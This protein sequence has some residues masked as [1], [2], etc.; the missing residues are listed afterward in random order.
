MG[1]NGL[2][3]DASGAID[4]SSYFSGYDPAKYV[5]IRERQFE[6]AKNI[7]KEKYGGEAE[8]QFRQGP[9][10]ATYDVI[11]E[12]RTVESISPQRIQAA[13]EPIMYD[14]DVQAYLNQEAL[15]RTYDKTDEDVAGML[16]ER[17][18]NL[19]MQAGAAKSSHLEKIYLDAA[20]ELESA[21]M[22]DSPKQ[23]YQEYIKDEIFDQAT[24]STINTFAFK[25]VFGGG[26]KSAKINEMFLHSWKKKYG[27]KPSS[28]VLI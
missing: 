19:R 1:N 3:L 26:V 20:D 28:L 11:V 24:K 9:G 13:V 8:L 16:V 25:S 21:A 14:P 4:D 7:V 27:K 22:S 17:A 18:D 23:K 5:N 6:A 12:G 10:G 15:F 2:Q